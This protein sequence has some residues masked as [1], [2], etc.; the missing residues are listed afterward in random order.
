MDD[1]LERIKWLMRPFGSDAWFTAGDA[2]ILLKITIGEAA[3]LLH[4]LSAKGFIEWTGRGYRLTAKE[5]G[6]AS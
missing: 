3:K 6:N 4:Q 1:E 2:A 5:R